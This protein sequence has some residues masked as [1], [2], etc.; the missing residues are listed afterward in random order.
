MPARQIWRSYSMPAFMN[1]SLLT[2]EKYDNAVRYSQI[3]LPAQKL[4]FLEENDT[5]HQYNDGPWHHSTGT[6]AWRDPMANWHRDRT[7]LAF[8]DG[9]ATLHEWVDASTIEMNNTPQREWPEGDRWP[10]YED[11]PTDWRFMYRAYFPRRTIS[12]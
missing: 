8:A 6:P 9:H 1:G 2:N 4:A 12:D 7:C 11:P 5:L 3:K 10:V